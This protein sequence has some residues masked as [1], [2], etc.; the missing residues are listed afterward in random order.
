[1]TVN[2][3]QKYAELNCRRKESNTV[4][5]QQLLVQVYSIPMDQSE[6]IDHQKYINIVFWG[7]GITID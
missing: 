1:M 7:A 4:P 6:V 3:W 2:G 5:S